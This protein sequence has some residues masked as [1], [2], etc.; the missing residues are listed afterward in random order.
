MYPTSSAENISPTQIPSQSQHRHYFRNV[1][2]TPKSHL[3]SQGYVLRR[4]SPSNIQIPQP[5][6]LQ[7][8]YPPSSHGSRDSPRQR[9]SQ[10]DEQPAKKSQS[11][12]HT[13]PPRKSLLHLLLSRRQIL[14][15]YRGVRMRRQRESRDRNH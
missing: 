10:R 2:E 7:R 8:R 3:K 15:L 14:R 6:S 13:P 4:K 12:P 11:S 9:P 1:H 5:P